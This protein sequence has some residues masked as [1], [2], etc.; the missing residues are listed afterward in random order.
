MV[1]RFFRRYQQPLLIVF[2]VLIIIS[3]VGFFDRSGFIDKAGGAQSATIYG[4]PVS[5][6][7]L[8]REG[9]KFELARNVG[10]QE[11]LTS[12]VGRAQT[13]AEAIENF[14]WNSMVLRHEA[15]QLGLTASDEEVLTAIQTMPV[16]QTNGT[17]DA[18]KYAMI[19]ENAL[20]PRGLS[21]E[22]LE[23]LVR[24]DLR[25]KKLKALL[26]ATVAPAPDEVRAMYDERYQKTE[27]SVV[28]IKLDDFLAAAT[29]PEEDVKKLYEDRKSQLKS[30]EKRKVKVAAFILPTTDKPLEGKERA[31]A[32]GKLG[33]AAEEF[34]VAMTEK[35]ADFTALAEKAGVKVEET[36]EFARREAP[37]ALGSSP[38]VAAAAFKL[39][40]KQPNSDVVTTER[41]YY[42]LQLAGI[43][44][45]RPLTFDEAKAQLVE[46]LKRER[47]QE[48]L[49]LKG[50]EI[51][52]KIETELKAG[53]SFAEAAQAAGV[54]A[55][56]FGTFS[57]ED[58][59]SLLNVFARTAPKFT[60]PDAR[61]VIFTA[62]E[63]KE[64][65]LS[66]LTPTLQGADLIHVDKRPPIDDAK[67]AEQ[68]EALAGNLAQFN[69]EVLFAEW[70]KLRRA[71]ARLMLPKRG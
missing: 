11:L 45:V 52:N 30:E 34:S 71:E 25:L 41:G 18:A 24:D 21:K 13:E 58:K 17:F 66:P 2:T 12:V 51:R 56:V 69:R 7:Q 60:Q 57:Q 31:E 62:L 44:E 32:L 4:N 27:A 14:T 55:E 67:F 68:K 26:G 5:Q 6:V 3:F 70:L 36:G 48:A 19:F 35:D 54:K 50:A 20:Q 40:A 61:E 37:A 23:D 28:R 53:K 64:G 39:S 9:R 38:A 59:E 63:M 33:R 65:A 8:Q 47:A 1:S 49:N 22:H 29:V 42:A 10:L 43:S 46:Q 15:N 16:F